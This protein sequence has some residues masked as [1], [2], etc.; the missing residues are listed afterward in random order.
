MFLRKRFTVKELLDSEESTGGRTG[1]E[2]EVPVSGVSGPGTGVPGPGTRVAEPVTGVSGSETVKSLEDNITKRQYVGDPFTFL[3][4]IIS[5][6]DPY[7]MNT[8]QGSWR[9]T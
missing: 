1:H 8:E 4:Y 3:A 9:K 6:S 5:A 7:K 2:T